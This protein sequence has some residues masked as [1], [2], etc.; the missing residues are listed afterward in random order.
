MSDSKATA[1]MMPD[2]Q[3]MPAG[4]FKEIVLLSHRRHLQ[5]LGAGSGDRLIVSTDWLAWDEALKSGHRAVL[6]DAFLTPWPEELGNPAEHHLHACAWV[7]DQNGRDMTLFRGIS[8][9]KTFV[10]SITQYALH[11]G[12]AWHG[13]DRLLSRFKPKRLVLLDLRL[14]QDLLNDAGK[15]DLVSQAALRHKVGFVDRLDAPPPGDPGFFETFEG[16]GSR[17]VEPWPRRALRQAYALGVDFLFRLRH[18]G[19]AKAVFLMLNWIAAKKL[20]DAH[21][22]SSKGPYPFPAFFAGHLPKS[23]AFLR[24]AWEKG[25]QLVA[26]PSASLSAADK[27]ALTGIYQQLES[28]WTKSAPNPVQQACRNFVKTVLV[29][30]RWFEAHAVE[31]KRYQ[32]FF[33]SRKFQRLVIGDGTST[34][35]RIILETARQAGVKIDEMLN[36]MFLTPQRYDV[37]N[38]DR[39]CKPAIDRLLSR[40]ERDERWLR[41]MDAPLEF[42]RIGYPALERSAAENA[43]TALKTDRALLLP[44]CADSDDVLVLNARLFALLLST[45]G[46]LLKFGVGHVRVKLHPGPPNLAYYRDLLACFGPRVE[47]VKDNAL[48]EHLK[49]ADFVV[50]PITSGAFLEALACGLPYY[51]FQSEISLIDES[52]VEGT[53][54]L[55]EAQHL[56]DKLRKGKRAESVST[57]E[58][59]SSYDSIPDSAAAFWQAM[60]EKESC[61][62]CA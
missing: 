46:A 22:R 2:W 60:L 41:L 7:Y 27:R 6:F 12:L 39:G 31:I 61:P 8:I 26:L 11:Y 45:V 32:R 40:G 35:S 28:A 17:M 9:G 37:R 47:V 53:G 18:R 10:R 42:C 5:A 4:P 13:L 54:V 16:M 51:P 15:R 36:G 55:H 34:P 43:P 20:L 25:A 48:A 59:F 19:K 56:I 23:I 24:H 3:A 62:I 30:S 33:E 29:E 21:P 38:G 44:I 14:P 58:D 57:L 50:G 52:M 49:W 1:A